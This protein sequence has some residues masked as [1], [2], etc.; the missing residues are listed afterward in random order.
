MVRAGDPIRASD[1]AVQGC[2]VSRNAAQSV[3]QGALVTVTFDAELFDNDAM[4]ST[5]TNNS[6]ITINTAG[7]Y[8][9]GFTGSFAAHSSYTRIFYNILL[10]GTTEIQRAGG[11][12]AAAAASQPLAISTVYS[13]NV[14]DYVEVQVRHDGTG[15]AQNLE[16]VADRSP[17]FYAAR[18]GS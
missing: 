11:F 13:L 15:S 6:R 4:H 9:I 7:I 8:V 14:G 16:V 2:R 17:Q 12:G 10:N 3:A 5:S 1:I 18:I